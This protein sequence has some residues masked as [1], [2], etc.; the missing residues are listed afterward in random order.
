MKPSV[1]LLQVF[2]LPASLKFYCDVL[3]FQVV[4][5]TDNDWWAMLKH[6]DAT[7]MLNTAYEDGQRPASPDPAR[8]RG[9]RD[10]SLY[11]EYADLDALYSHLRA[12]GC[13]VTPP[14]VTSYGL[15]QMDISDPDGYELCF[16]A[17][18]DLPF[19]T[20]LSQLRQ[21]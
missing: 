15:R 13:Q 1:P 6:G 19:E 14:A 20:K 3:E 18:A 16:T 21:E 7:L 8:V 9:H 11:F 5:R 10:V 2:D 17:P 12:H 4:Q